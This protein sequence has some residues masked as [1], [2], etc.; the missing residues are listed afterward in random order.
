MF[1]II[2]VFD[3]HFKQNNTTHVYNAV[4]IKFILFH[5]NLHIILEIAIVHK[6]DEKAPL[7][8]LVQSNFP[9]FNRKH[10]YYTYEYL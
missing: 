9:N 8:I 6:F 2:L 4:T 5:V 7:T 10:L 3:V 1:F